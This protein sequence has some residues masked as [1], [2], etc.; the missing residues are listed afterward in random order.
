MDKYRLA[1][2]RAK[3]NFSF[4]FGAANDNNGKRITAEVC[5]HMLHF[6][7]RDHA[8]RG[9]LIKCNPA[10]KTAADLFA[11]KDRG[12]IREGY[13]AGLVLIEHRSPT[14][15]RREDVLSKCGW[16]PFAGTTFRSSIDTT[17]VNG[18]GACENG[19]VTAAVAGQRLDCG[20]R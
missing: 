7:D 12:Y 2:G 4:Y 15:V 8:A 6:D 11:I 1:R 18:V 14:T 16:S 10:I 17:V 5:V 20:G 19:E 13:F 3:A 9:A